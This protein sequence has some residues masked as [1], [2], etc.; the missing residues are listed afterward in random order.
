M[1]LG[2]VWM[3]LAVENWKLLFQ[4]R[5]LTPGK[6]SGALVLFLGL[7]SLVCHC[8]SVCCFSKR[9]HPVGSARLLNEEGRNG[10]A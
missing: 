4:R 2:Y 1:Q 8:S 9:S 3:E 7:T 6:V 10:E 5:S